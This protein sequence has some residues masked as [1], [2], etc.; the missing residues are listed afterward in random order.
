MREEERRGGGKEEKR[1][2]KKGSWKKES[3]GT[4]G[5]EMTMRID[6][7]KGREGYGKDGRGEAR[8]GWEYGGGVVVTGC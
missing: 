2:E 3:R 6:D 4:G 7:K 8:L 1:K 5:R